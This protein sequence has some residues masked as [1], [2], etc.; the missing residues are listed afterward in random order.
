ME[1]KYAGELSFLNEIGA[2]RASGFRHADWLLSDYDSAVWQA[3]FGLAQPLTWSF[4][5]ALY[6]GTRLTDPQHAE[7][8]DVLRQ[9][10]CVQSNPAATRS[11]RLHPS[12][13]RARVTRTLH[14]ID[15]VLLN[16]R[17]LQ[18]SRHGLHLLNRNDLSALLG[19]LC[20]SADIQSAVYQ[21]PTRLSSLLLDCSRSL[22]DGD[23]ADTCE[24]APGVDADYDEEDAT[25]GLDRQQLLR[26]RVW[27]WRE[28]LYRRGPNES[29]RPDVLALAERLYRN[30]LWGVQRRS[31]P[32]ELCFGETEAPSHEKIR[33]AVKN[34]EDD[35]PD[36]RKV[37][38]YI[39]NIR[40]LRLVAAG[41]GPVP[42]APFALLDEESVLAFADLKDVGRHRSLPQSVVFAALRRAIDF[43]ISYGND[44]I[45][46]YLSI[47]RAAHQE[48]VDFLTVAVS[49]QFQDLLTPSLRALG[50]RAW[51]IRPLGFGRY[52]T[53]MGAQ[54]Y[55]QA[56]R[57]NEGLYELMRVLVG[58]VSICVG[59]TMA[60][61]GGELRDLMPETSLDVS[62]RYLVFKNRKSGESAHRMEEARPIPPIASE[63]IRMLERLHREISAIPG[64]DGHSALLA[65]PARLSG[66]LVSST[67]GLYGCLDLF[68]DYFELDGDSA[69]NRFYIRQHQLR[70]FFA[71]AFFW[72]AGFGGLDTLRWFLGHLDP[73][74]LWH[75]VTHSTPGSVLRV[76]QADYA[77]DR[78]LAHAPE[79]AALSELLAAHFGTD[80][81]SVLDSEELD[82]YMDELVLQGN[83]V[84]EPEFVTTD[85]EEAYRILIRVVGEERG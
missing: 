67:Q 28:G 47:A 37:T 80:D 32:P 48:G 17:D 62:G 6:D 61:R 72:A 43:S 16:G 22:T 36:L 8:L 24:R 63:L 73:R 19:A 30:T 68:C 84:V 21:W 56:L 2:Q 49:P 31:T 66:R 79:A 81:F 64:C 12:T 3:D 57:R 1:I 60:R 74:H 78:L 14:L 35:R 50:L 15:Y 85:Q 23:L 13:A 42:L 52:T 53:V 54:E 29:F 51:A 76:V 69:D 82:T 27:L 34:F 11:R 83:V 4:A 9:W 5:A 25:L 45:D 33:V 18:I 44:L 41:G 20:S 58:C 70:Q 38:S 65:H 77:I 40:G 46:S 39:D 71:I 59:A 55:F 10:L 75:Y 26:A 7:F